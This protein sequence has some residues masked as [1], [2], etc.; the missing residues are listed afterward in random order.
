MKYGGTIGFISTSEENCMY[1]TN[2]DTEDTFINRTINGLSEAQTGR[3]MLS[4][5]FALLGSGMCL[6]CIVGRTEKTL[7]H[8][9]LELDHFTCRIKL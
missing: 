6:L 2:A 8:R 5:L 3:H 7:T 4:F 9:G 1:A